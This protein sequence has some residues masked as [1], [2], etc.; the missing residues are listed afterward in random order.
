MKKG[1]LLIMVAMLLFSQKSLHAYDDAKTHPDI[2]QASIDKSRLN[3]FLI[4]NLGIL[5]GKNKTYYG[6]TITD[7]LESGSTNEDHPL[8]RAQNHF[9]NPINNT[10]LG[11]I[12][13]GKPNRDWAMGRDG[14][15]NPIYDC[16]DDND[17]CS[18]TGCSC[19]AYS[20]R[21]AGD[22]YY[23]ALTS[24]SETERNQ[25]FIKFWESLGRDLHLLEDM[26]VPA[27]TRNDMSGHLYFTGNINNIY[28]SDIRSY[29]AYMSSFGNLYEAYVKDTM[30]Y[31]DITALLNQSMIVPD[32]GK[33]ED[34]WDD[35]IY[36]GTSPG[37][38]MP[39]NGKEQSGLAE[40]SNANFIS[41]CVMFTS[42][43]PQSDEH[44]FPYPRE[45]S[46][47]ERE[48]TD[49]VA[50]DG[51]LDRVVYFDKV[52]DGE[53]IPFFVGQKYT[54]T[55]LEDKSG[56]YSEAYNLEYCM[57]DTNYKAHA[58][59]LIPKTV[60]YATGLI[61]NFFRGSIEITLPDK[62][63]YAYQNSEP[64][65]PSTMGFKH[66][67]L[68]ARNNSPDQE[69]IMDG[70]TVDLIVQYRLLETDPFRNYNPYP[71]PLPAVHYIK[72]SL[73]SGSTTQSIDRNTTIE[74]NFDLPQE[75]PL[76]ATDLYLQVIYKGKLR[77]GTVTDENAVCVGNKDICEPT[78]IDFFNNTDFQCMYDNWHFSD[79]SSTAAEAV[80]L[81]YTSAGGVLSQNCTGS[82]S[83]TCIQR[84][85][86]DY[87]LPKTIVNNYIRFSPV[88][89]PQNATADENGHILNIQDL[90][91]AECKRIY[92]LS[93]YTFAFDMYAPGWDHSGY[94]THSGI[95]N[96]TDYVQNTGGTPY[97]V[98]YHPLFKEYRESSMWTACYFDHRSI[99][100]VGGCPGLDASKDCDILG[101]DVGV[102]PVQ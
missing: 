72:G 92:L 70:G 82:C 96:Q 28:W 73:V 63:V 13:E 80:D 60:A 9:W 49:V 57:D 78:P 74:L 61:N 40:Y 12:F 41:D 87:V 36:A 77:K 16:Q 48:P 20:W 65:N 2:T 42:I 53:S 11:D 34:Y 91:N 68:K 85:L 7:L 67:T 52:G 95:K 1:L 71:A 86:W 25:H 27:H 22:E 14:N 94:S 31:S 3:D 81:G 76:W 84:G 46:L 69:L 66:I 90:K 47:S 93:D 43:L 33:T 8:N 44:Y 56:Q 88:D 32:F 50:E 100:D 75:I 54:R 98:R 17:Y 24:T 10:G 35:E 23:K 15:W 97:Y 39:A 4:Y 37:Q 18:W 5:E 21:V 51:I 55:F 30:S 38:T 102:I 59:K 62:G 6:R 79:G 64:A 99:Y 19:N 26:G 45:S 58:Q 83:N 101:I 89:R 29:F